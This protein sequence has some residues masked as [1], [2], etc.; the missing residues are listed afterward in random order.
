MKGL[1]SFVHS[2]CNS[3]FQYCRV[4]N[5]LL[6]LSH[7]SQ[8][9]LIELHFNFYIFFDAHKGTF[10]LQ[11]QFCQIQDELNFFSKNPKGGKISYFINSAQNGLTT[12]SARDIIADARVRLESVV[13]SKLDFMIQHTYQRKCS[14]TLA[15]T[16]DWIKRFAKGVK[17]ATFIEKRKKL[18]ENYLHKPTVSNVFQSFQLEG[19]TTWKGKTI[20]F[21]SLCKKTFRKLTPKLSFNWIGFSPLVLLCLGG[22]NCGQERK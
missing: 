4:L 1:L 13:P 8:N 5:K 10:F 19:L 12:D 18:D 22:A 7:I 21:F 2:F 20:L 11:F 16:N 3:T 6:L 17:L 14:N 9:V 15:A